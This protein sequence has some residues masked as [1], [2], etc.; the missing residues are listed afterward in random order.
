M[1]EDARF[2]RNTVIEHTK[3]F[4]ESLPMIASENILSPLAREMMISDFHSRYAEG[5]V[6]KRY[7]EG[8]RFVDMVEQKAIDLA[9]QLFDCKF[10]DV[11]A[12]S[13]TV[14]N[15]AVYFALTKPGD[16]VATVSLSDGGHISAAS[17]G[18]LGLRGLKTINFP[19]DAKIMNIDVAKTKRMLKKARPKVALFGMSTFLF[20]TPIKELKDVMSDIGCYAWYDAAH[21]LGLIGGGLFQ[22]PLK[23]GV[24]IMTAST[25][26]TFPGPQHGIILANPRDDSMARAL[27]RGVFPGITS[28]HH[29]HS[30]AALA[31]ALAEHIEFGKEYARQTVANAKA[32]AQAMHERGI[33]VLC[34][35]LGFTQSHIVL[36]N[37]AKNGGGH[38]VA[39]RLANCNIITNKNLLPHDR[40][41][42]RP[43]GIRLGTQELTRIGMKEKDMVDVAELLR[44]AILKREDPKK[45][46]RDVRELRK[47]FTKIEYCFGAGMPAF[48]HLK[49]LGD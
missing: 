14:A 26:K 36:I 49:I 30:V 4:S 19:F 40:S 32:L 5:T 3:F 34:P 16:L 35:D 38:E 7:Y 31:I 45:V 47:N 25:H 8:N 15:A 18:A 13:G 33:T 22:D 28:N 9:K 46:A 44:R 17:F 43:S 12:I 41:S 48:E 37:V 21:V 1:N 20:P 6:G 24:E 42:K 39:A 29:L 10:A 2:V 23:E 11:R 27:E